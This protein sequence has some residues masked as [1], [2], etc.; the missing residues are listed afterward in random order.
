MRSRNGQVETTAGA[1]RGSIE[2]PLPIDQ[3]RE[4]ELREFSRATVKKRA[5]R[6]EVGSVRAKL[7]ASAE[8][9]LAQAAAQI[10]GRP[11]TERIPD[12]DYA[13]FKR[14]V[15]R[16]VHELEQ[17]QLLSTLEHHAAVIDEPGPYGPDSPNSYYADL[18][19]STAARIEVPDLLRARTSDV[20]MRHEAVQ[21][22]LRRHSEDVASA[23]RKGDAYGKRAKA[24]LSESWREEDPVQHRQRTERELRAFTTGGGAT[25]SAAG[26][27]GAA[28]VSPAFLLAQR[29]PYRSPIRT[30]AD[31]CASFPLPDYGMQVY[32]PTFTTADKA[33]EQSES[34]TVAETVPATGF[35]GAAVKT[36]TGQLL[37]SQQ[38]RDRMSPGGGA[39]DE[40]VSQEMNWRLDEVIGKYVLNQALA[41]ASIISGAS[42]YTEA[43]FWKDLASARESLSDTAGTRLR[44]TSMFTTTDLYGFVTRQ[45]DKST[46]RPIWPPWYA[47]AFP[48]AADTDDFRGPDWPK[49]AR[50]MGTVMPGDLVWLT[51]EA[52]PN[53]GTTSFTQIIVSAPAVAMVFCEGEGVVSVFPETKATELNVLLNCR[54]YVAAITRHAAGTATIQ[55]A[56]YAAAEK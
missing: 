19:A 30:F 27:G 24:I 29:A 17:D 43:G 13:S 55:G 51:D 8:G 56:A 32:I 21:E 1:I 34:A 46:E 12:S 47:T 2:D 41:G 9:H 28:F 39:F 22:R 26:G 48:L 14:S 33:G 37:I 25:A 18:A 5:Q 36:I 38:F 40:L 20:D 49:Y 35:E 54:K 16:A 10:G 44:A 15:D 3:E 6:H 42:A 52:I 7:R 23:I 50:Y 11:A 45:V 31:Q 4:R 53:Y